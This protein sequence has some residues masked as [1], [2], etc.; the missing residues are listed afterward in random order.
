[1]MITDKGT[2]LINGAERVIVSQLH[3]SPGVFFSD[4]I[5]PNGRRLF[6]SRI[7][8]YRGSWD[9]KYY[10]ETAG[11]PVAY[12]YASPEAKDTIALLEAEAAALG[13]DEME[14]VRAH[15]FP[16]FEKADVP[17]DA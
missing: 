8:P 17:V 16:A 11:K 12:F 3:R 2:F 14:Y 10:D 7:I 1:P 13:I 6:R 5:H 15:Y 4:E 9:I